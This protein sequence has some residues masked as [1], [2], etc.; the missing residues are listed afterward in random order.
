[1]KEKKKEKNI[2]S[3]VYKKGVQQIL[4]NEKESK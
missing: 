2:F 3:K 4:S 1:M